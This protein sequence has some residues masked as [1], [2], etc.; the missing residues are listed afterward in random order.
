MTAKTKGAR[1]PKK[2]TPQQRLETAVG[3]V[4][5]AVDRLVKAIEREGVALKREEIVKAFSFIGHA[6]TAAQQRAL[7]ALTSAELKTFSVD[8]ELPALPSPLPQVATPTSVPLV[9]PAVSVADIG[10]R[11]VQEARVQRVPGDDKHIDP[12]KPA[13]PL[14]GTGF[15]DDEEDE[16]VLS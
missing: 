5:N 10:G 11:F 14:E 6:A 1:A 15:I 2:T 8:A 3:T 9:R 7:A 13:D 12:A 4:R 16:E